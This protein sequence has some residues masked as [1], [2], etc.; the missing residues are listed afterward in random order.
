[1]VFLDTS[2]LIYSV[3]Q[4]PGWGEKAAARLGALHAGGDLDGGHV[5][6]ARYPPR[7]VRR[8]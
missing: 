2:V 5:R 7:Q 6:Q 1:M 4:P 3:E 8:G